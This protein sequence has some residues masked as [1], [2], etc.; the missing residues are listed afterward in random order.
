MLAGG[1]LGTVGT[2]V[3]GFGIVGPGV[4]MGLGVA[5]ELG[6]GIV[7]G[8]GVA[9]GFGVGI[10]TMPP[11]LKLGVLALTVLLLTV[12]GGKPAFML[13]I[14][15]GG[16]LGNGDVGPPSGPMPGPVGG[17]MLKLPLF[18]FAPSGGRPFSPIPVTGGAVLTFMP[19]GSTA[20][21]SVLLLG[22]DL[23]VKAQ[24]S[25]KVTMRPA[26]A[27]VAMRQGLNSR[28]G[29][30]TRPGPIG[31][32]TGGTLGA[33]RMAGSGSISPLTRLWGKLISLAALARVSGFSVKGVNGSWGVARM[34]VVSGSKASSGTVAG[35]SSGTGTISS[36]N[37]NLSVS[38]VAEKYAFLPRP[39][40]SDSRRQTD[41]ETPHH[42]I[43][44]YKQ[45]IFSSI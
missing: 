18:M 20:S 2:G 33:G 17:G 21:G 7:T 4:A 27:K 5:L 45:G 15:A 6:V 28:T 10:V 34:S 40:A 31:G 9:P 23:L 8:L 37:V 30:E 12:G 22:V 24:I 1:G 14:L 26:S 38:E 39:P 3:G 44:G 16:P 19:L 42:D 35:G 36:G 41:R 11:L 43:H 13:R 32:M 29:V 25:P